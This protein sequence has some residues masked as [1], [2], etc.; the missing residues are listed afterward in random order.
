MKNNDL[1][2][3]AAHLLK[4]H[5]TMNGRLFG[6]VGAV[7]ISSTG[8]RYV[9]VCVDTPSWGLCAERSAMAAMVTNG[10]YRF[11]KAV[12]VWRDQQTGRLH[13]L[14]PCGVCREFMRQV[15][16]GNLDAEIV[17]DGERTKMLRELIP[18][19]EWPEPI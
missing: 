1:I 19:C 2:E 13:V 3:Q 4:P 14:P 15:D 11:R 5:Q 9:G 10:E 8:N 7:V 18:E 12:A 17:L 16:E 6:D